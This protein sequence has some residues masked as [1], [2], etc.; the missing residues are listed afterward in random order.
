MENR[1]LIQILFL[2]TQ[3]AFSMLA[4]IVLCA[5]L[6]IWLGKKS[7]IS[8]LI[9][10]FLAVGILAGF[11]NTYKLLKK[12][13]PE[14]DKRYVPRREPEKR[15]SPAEKEFEAW[16]KRKQSEETEHDEP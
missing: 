7:G 6:G 5:V 8:W 13:L 3:I 4:P 12:H 11:R 9:L 14:D 1:K 16:K 2:V 15:L 10:V